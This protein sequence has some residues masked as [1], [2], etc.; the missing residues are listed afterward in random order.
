MKAEDVERYTSH[1]FVCYFALKTGAAADMERSH[2]PEWDRHYDSGQEM[3]LPGS[4][5]LPTDAGLWGQEE[6]QRWM[7]IARATEE[8]NRAALPSGS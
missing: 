3:T 2:V 4:G 1:I 8:E 5:F 7:D 6:L